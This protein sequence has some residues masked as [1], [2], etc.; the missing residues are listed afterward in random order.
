MRSSLPLT[1]AV[2]VAPLLSL[3]GARSAA[4]GAPADTR[5]RGVS[6]HVIAAGGSH[7]FA[8]VKDSV[9]GVGGTY[10]WGTDTSYELGNGT[11]AANA[12]APV[13]ITSYSQIAAGKSFTVAIDWAGA[14][15]G[16]G[17]TDKGQAGTSVSGTA[18]STAKKVGSKIWKSLAAGVNHACGITADGNLYCWG[19]N[20]MGELAKDPATTAQTATPT[21]VGAT[22]D[23]WIA[24]ACG[25]KFTYAIK[26]NGALYSW[27]SNST[28]GAVSGQLGQGYTGDLSRFAVN[29]I[30]SK[31][32][33]GVAAGASHGLGI[34]EDGTLWA[35][36]YNTSYQLGTGDTTRQS[37]PVQLLSGSYF[38]AVSAGSKSSYAIRSD[39]ALL[40]WGDNTSGQLG[41]CSAPQKTPGTVGGGLY[42]Y[43]AGGADFALAVAA[44]GELRTFG[45]NGSGQLGRTGTATAP[46]LVPDTAGA[47]FA[48]IKPP[49]LAKG[50]GVGS[51][52]TY[53]G[54][55]IK[56]SGVLETWGYYG[57][58]DSTGVMG[59]A[60]T[61]TGVFNQLAT[62]DTADKICWEPTPV[63][64]V[65][66]GS[67]YP[68]NKVPWRAVSASVSHMLAIRADG[69]L[70]AWGGN[71]QGEVGNGTKNVVNLP[72]KIGSDT[73]WKV[74]ADETNSHSYGIRADG[75]LWTW[76]GGTTSPTQLCTSGA[77]N[78]Y[79]FAVIAPGLTVLAISTDGTLWGA[80]SGITMEKLDNHNSDSPASWAGLTWLDAQTY[81]QNTSAIDSSGRLWTWGYNNYGQCGN[82]TI[83]NETADGL[84]VK[85]P[86]AVLSNV[87]AASQCSTSALALTAD[88]KPYGW[89]ENH[90][91]ELG[92]SGSEMS[93][94]VNLLTGVPTSG[95]TRTSYWSGARIT[96]LEC[97]S[98]TSVASDRSGWLWSAGE[99]D[100]GATGTGVYTTT[101]PSTHPLTQEHPLYPDGYEANGLSASVGNPQGLYSGSSWSTGVNQANGQ[102]FQM[103][104][105]T[106]AWRVTLVS[107]A[108][109]LVSTGATDYPRTFDVRV[110]DDGTNFT[111]VA[112]GVKGTGQTMTIPIGPQAAR[113]IRVVITA[114]ANVPWGILSALVEE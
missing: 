62:C 50:G 95:T 98:D 21:L 40:A 35:W 88:F 60:S 63:A 66:S 36:G 33:V 99:T 79:R 97:G 74:V 100:D 67:T 96:S 69:S 44:N 23:R 28:A 85:I 57:D 112:A 61:Q 47:S 70:W 43:V 34:Q 89:G 105:G 16:W 93:S 106:S 27:G 76:G 32:W 68:A 109:R 15:W 101:S 8:I 45:N 53:T 52:P 14:L 51:G 91:G 86:N 46:A 107:T 72:V 4:A 19:D 38:M 92:V 103:D 49:V 83:S 9:F 25:D 102:W 24:V 7:A 64:Y 22:S 39:G 20:S 56:S 77:C 113:Y 2:V 48:A 59:L 55:R 73:W 5:V 75:T 18:Q 80:N 78:G 82:G 108:I 54:A 10:A 29:Q 31:R 6:S 12:A 84:P 37:A 87:V 17:L 114:A 71:T 3:A 41:C 42:Q 81:A 110:S 13:S 90:D 1:L 30:G 58:A 94:P 111:T 65:T 11:P 26:A 104:L